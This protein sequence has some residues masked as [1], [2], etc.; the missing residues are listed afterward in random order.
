MLAA[1]QA[2][3]LAPLLLHFSV[4]KPRP[5][6][7]L[8]YLLEHPQLASPTCVKTLFA[9]CDE[10]KGKKQLLS[11]A[12]FPSPSFLLYLPFNLNMGVII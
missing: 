12:S 2:G 7:D 4:P 8:D 10:L 9:M 1:A 3:P 5:H 6:D 11:G